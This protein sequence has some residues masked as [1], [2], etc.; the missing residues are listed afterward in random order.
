MEQCRNLH[1]HAGTS[2]IVFIPKSKVQLI[3]L[4]Q[5]YEVIYDKLKATI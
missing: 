2:Y 4:F 5:R 1:N 3:L